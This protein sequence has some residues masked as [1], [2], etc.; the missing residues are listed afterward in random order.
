MR[1]YLGIE[2]RMWHRNY[3]WIGGK[4]HGNRGVLWEWRAPDFQGGTERGLYSQLFLEYLISRLKLFFSFPFFFFFFRAA[5]TAYGI[6]QARGEIGAEAAGYT[7]A[8]ATHDMRCVCN[9]HHSS[10]QQQILN[11]LIKAR[12]WT[13]I[14]M[15]TSCVHSN[16]LSH[17]GN[18][19]S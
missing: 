7:T 4:K 3:L 8:T 2:S 19:L 10:W 11:P 13:C 16:L 15:D 17:S 6:S 9:L 5:P 12:D 18:S 14:L 1:F